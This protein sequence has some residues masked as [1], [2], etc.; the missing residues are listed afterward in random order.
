MVLE[1]TGPPVAVPTPAAHRVVVIGAGVAGLTAAHE[2]AERGFEVTVYERK[3][4]GGKSRSIP[5]PGSA[6]GE[7][8]ELPG[9]HGYRFVPGFYQHLPDT[10][11]RIP[12]L[13]DDRSVWDH[14]VPQ[15]GFLYARSGRRENLPVLSHVKGVV[16]RDFLRRASIA[17]AQHFKALPPTQLARFVARLFVFMTSSEERR[18]GEWEYITWSDFVRAERMGEQ[19]RAL[20][21]NGV[22]E[23]LIAARGDLAS[24]RSIGTLGEAYLYAVMRLSTTGESGRVLDAPSSESWIDPWVAYLRS[25]GVRFVVGVGAQAF[26]MDQGRVSAVRVAG[27]AVNQRVEADWYICAVPVERAQM[28]LTDDVLTADPSLAGLA[29]LR[30]EWMNGIQFYLRRPLRVIGGPVL[31]VDSPW[32]L[33]SASQAQWWNRNL[34]SGYGDGTVRE[35]LSVNIA[36]FDAPGI[37][38]G[39]PA[40]KC[41]PDEIATE[42]LTQIRASLGDTGRNVL[43]DGAIASWFLDPA[44]RFDN[45]VVTNDEPLFVNYTGS[46]DARPTATTA[47]PN[48]F[49]AG[50]YVRDSLSAATMEGANQTGRLAANGVLEASGSI[51]SP[52]RIFLP[53]DPPALVALKRRDAD[54]F[55][56]GLPHV[57]DRM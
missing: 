4:L 12:S 14:M 6:N 44:L 17:L 55:R 50:D 49:L 43:P 34:Q 42:V 53:Y 10:M 39:K 52:S 19:Y 7:R 16:T 1:A 29:Q 24:A 51:A 22:T 23:H 15:A 32:G 40:T 27:P 28:L 41:T 38:Y 31:Y 2:L 37:V 47:I 20:L 26:E 25:K 8:K 35:C 57:L 46:W 9:E 54:R 3:A 18:F 45:G 30:T 11:A 13:D 48:L 33:V 56:R 21:V 5:V 36:N